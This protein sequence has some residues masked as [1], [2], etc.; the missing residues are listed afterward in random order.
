MFAKDDWVSVKMVSDGSYWYIDGHRFR[1]DSTPNSL[2]S[3]NLVEYF[4]PVVESV[5]SSSDNK[6]LKLEVP[7][8]GFTF[9][10]KS[11][12]CWNAGSYWY[13]WIAVDKVSKV[14]NPNVCLDCGWICNQQCFKF[15]KKTYRKK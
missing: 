2:P 12:S 7:L 11:W 4:L 8:D 10:N 1:P 13:I 14:E 5:E 6:F 3:G 15:N 9:Q